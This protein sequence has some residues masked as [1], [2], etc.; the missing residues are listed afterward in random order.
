MNN[1]I[2]S[3][4]KFINSSVTLCLEEESLI[5][6]YFEI[7]EYQKNEIILNAGEI[8]NYLYFIDKGLLRT[9][10]VN[11]NGSEFTRL[12]VSENKFCTILLSFQERIASPAT[13]QALENTI[14]FAISK[15]NFEK[16]TSIS[17]NAQSLYVKILEEFQN[18]QIK[19]IEFLTSFTPKEKTE[20]FLKENSE[21]ETRLTDKVIASY[22]QITPE[23][24][25]RCKKNLES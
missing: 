22:L 12:I 25:C 24:Y 2:D 20:I 19:R 5:S 7:K 15:E 17:A 16:I 23:T 10:H 18:F 3:L 21:L 13:I 11:A 6:K 14:V 8:C 4:L 1:S 9:F